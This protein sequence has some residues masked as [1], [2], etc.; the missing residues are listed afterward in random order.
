[1][2]TEVHGMKAQALALAMKAKAREGGAAST[3]Q[4]YGE[5]RTIILVIA[6]VAVIA[7]VVAMGMFVFGTLL[8]QAM[9]KGYDVKD[10][11]YQADVGEGQTRQSHTLGMDLT[12]PGSQPAA[13]GDSS[14]VSSGA[15][16]LLT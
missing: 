4:T 8:M 2:H 5:P 11:K 15:A 14:A 1:M 16:T 12:A 6:I 7:V 9:N 10:A 13:Q 3:G